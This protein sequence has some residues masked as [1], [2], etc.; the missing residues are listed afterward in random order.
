MALFKTYGMQNGD[1]VIFFLRFFQKSEILKNAVS[2]RWCLD[3]SNNTEPEINKRVNS[4]MKL[5]HNMSIRTLYIQN[6]Q[7]TLYNG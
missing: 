5:E 1:K 4:K 2:G 6:Q 7:C 3:S